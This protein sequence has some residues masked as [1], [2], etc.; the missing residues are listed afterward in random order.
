MSEDFTKRTKRDVD[1]VKKDTR[2]LFMSV[3]ANDTS[4]VIEII[5]NRKPVINARKKSTN[6]TLLH[7]ACSKGNLDIV[8]CLCEN[9]ANVEVKDDNGETPLHFACYYGNF[10]I[11][12]YL[13]EVKEAN[14]EVENNIGITS[15][16]V[17][18]MLKHNRIVKYIENIINKRNLESFQ[19]SIIDNKEQQNMVV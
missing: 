9:G 18:R 3:M 4:S 12:K 10:S 7:I 16:N 19:A 17:A 8:K 5:K 11:V 2:D 13:C 6:E 14:I 1:K 15:L